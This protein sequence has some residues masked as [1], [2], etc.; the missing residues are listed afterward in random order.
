MCEI[1]NTK[2]NFLQRII[3]CCSGTDIIE[4]HT[5][6]EQQ[7]HWISVGECGRR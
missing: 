1:K 4:E 5:W 3:K 2:E 7:F 6:T